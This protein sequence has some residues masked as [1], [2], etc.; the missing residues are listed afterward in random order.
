M[1]DALIGGVD[2]TGDVHLDAL[3]GGEDDAGA[4]VELEELG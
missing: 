1:V 3:V 4:A 2:L